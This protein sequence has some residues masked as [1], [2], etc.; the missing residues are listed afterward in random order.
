MGSFGAGTMKSSSDLPSQSIPT[1]VTLRDGA[2]EYQ[3][4][5]HSTKE[6][7]RATRMFDKEKGTIAW[8]DRE[9]RPDDVFFDIGANIGVYTIFGARRIGTAGA[10]F[11]F[12][13]HI[14][15]AN[16]LI[17]NILLNGQAHKVRLVSAALSNRE[18]YDA[19]NYQS[20]QTASSTSQYG[21]HA[22]EGENFDPVFVEIKHG[23]TVDTLCAKGVLRAP[24]VVKIDVDGLDFEVL[25]GM[26]GL[27]TSRDAPRSVQVEL[28]SDSKPK[29]MQ[30]CKD[31]GYV[32]TE[33]HWTQA[34]LDFIAEGNDPEDYP[35]YG[36]FYHADVAA[37]VS[38]K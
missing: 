4:V 7:N 30:L 32:L 12:E 24:D 10:V 38:Q 2:Y 6:R 11:A 23:C 17:E 28:G 1:V 21:R 36:I 15:N 22:Y 26:R 18:S 20:L 25:D 19:F 13:P 31:V 9:L 29:I 27:L 16:S 14:P 37:A 35:H 33:K 34:G 5:C 3:F 8:L